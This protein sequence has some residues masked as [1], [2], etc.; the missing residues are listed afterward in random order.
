METDEV[1]TRRMSLTRI[2]SLRKDHRDAVNGWEYAVPAK[3]ERDINHLAK[4][5]ALRTSAVEDIKILPQGVMI[6][7]MN[8]IYRIEY[9][10]SNRGATEQEEE[11]D[12]RRRGRKSRRSA[13]G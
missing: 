13:S 9:L 7:T 6:E 5:R 4:K 11:I 12:F 1:Q 8:S 2:E 3:E 10:E